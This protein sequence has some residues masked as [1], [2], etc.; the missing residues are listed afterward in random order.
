[1]PTITLNFSEPVQSS[2]QINDIAYYVPVA[3]SGGFVTQNNDIIKI[4][5]ITSVGITSIICDIDISTVPPTAYD[6]NNA[7][8]DMIMFSKDNAA[9]MSSLLGYYAKVQLTNN[10]TLE[11]ELF[12]LESDY[13]ESSK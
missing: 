3:S 2:V 11:S 4:G 7:T 5:K 8:N 12:T 13:F 1:M 6:P 9:N 10:S